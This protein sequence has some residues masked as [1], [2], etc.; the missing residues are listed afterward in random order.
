MICST[1]KN[2][3]GSDEIQQR[4]SHLELSKPIVDHQGIVDPILAVLTTSGGRWFSG[5][6]HQPM[7]I[8]VLVFTEA[9]QSMA[10]ALGSGAC[11]G[12]HRVALNGGSGR[13]DFIILHQELWDIQWYSMIF[14][15]R[16]DVKHDSE[17]QNDLWISLVKTPSWSSC[18][19]LS[20]QIFH[21]ISPSQVIAIST[22]TTRCGILGIG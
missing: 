18:F 17:I 10:A 15:V 1:N 13:C 12:R 21:Q 2:G 19:T 16:F 8:A 5:S 3:D 7:R 14:F 4:I 11:L 20:H 9:L 6:T 22:A